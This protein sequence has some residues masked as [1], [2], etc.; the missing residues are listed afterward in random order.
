MHLIH[1]GIVNKKYKENL[2]NSFKQ[3]FK[4][5]FGIETDIHATKD[6]K[7]V[8]YHDF[9]LKKNF[10]KAAKYKKPKLSKSKGNQS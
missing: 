7:F 10:Q 8:C 3:S 1:R 5:G 6:Y 4:K 2:L 9:T